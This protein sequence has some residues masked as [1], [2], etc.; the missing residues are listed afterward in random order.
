MGD[1]SSTGEMTPEEAQRTREVMTFL[2]EFVPTAWAFFREC[3]NSPLA[4]SFI[5]RASPVPHER[6]NPDR[7]VLAV[8]HRGRRALTATEP[9]VTTATKPTEISAIPRIV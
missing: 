4:N 1:R 8:N 6:S 3:Q 9:P 2:N 5:A 7:I